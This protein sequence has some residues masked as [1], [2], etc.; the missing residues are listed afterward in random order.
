MRPSNRP[1]RGITVRPRNGRW[2]WQLRLKDHGERSGT[3]DTE[4]DA[5]EMA[6]QERKKVLEA[7][8]DIYKR[9]ALK[10]WT[11]KMLIEGYLTEGRAAKRLQSITG[12]GYV[13]GHKLKKSFDH[14]ERMLR[15]FM[16]S[17]PALCNKS[18]DHDLTNDFRAYRDKR[19]KQVCLDTFKRQANPI[20]HIFKLAIKEWQLPIKNPFTDLSLQ[21]SCQPKER[22]VLSKDQYKRLLEI[23]TATSRHERQ[24]NLWLAIV[25]TALH[26]AMR[27]AEMLKAK[28]GDVNLDDLIWSIP[29]KNAKNGL[30]RKL[31]IS[32][33]LLDNL[34][35]YR[36]QLTEESKAIEA[37]V[38]QSQYRRHTKALSDSAKIHT[39]ERYLKKA[40]IKDFTFHDLRH[41]ATTRFETE[42]GLVNSEINYMKDGRT[43]SRYLHADIERIRAKLDKDYQERHI[44]DVELYPLRQLGKQIK[45]EIDEQNATENVYIYELDRERS[46]LTPVM[47][48]RHNPETKTNLYSIGEAAALLKVGIGDLVTNLDGR[49][50]YI[51]GDLFASWRELS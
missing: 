13:K 48:F 33:E 14:E 44:P 32:K 19:L 16:A 45:E 28:W 7:D 8:I 3:R 47:M 43:G 50:G 21:S 30:S 10:Q 18:L 23:I 36:H 26:T 35:A 22:N 29:A 24:A 25:V 15:F 46:V 9:N 39:F 17:E 6:E 2:Q 38:F 49:G 4:A 20:R 34:M 11:L 40:D 27:G 31:P 5:W 37:P 1:S 51:S 12:Q 42:L 41:T